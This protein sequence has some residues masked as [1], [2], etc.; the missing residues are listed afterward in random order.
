MGEIRKPFWKRLLWP[1]VLALLA[2]CAL[3][4]DMSV[5]HYFH[6][7]PWRGDLSKAVALC[8]AFGY[9]GTVLFILL[10]AACLDPR[11][12]RVLPRLALASYGGGLSA[13]LVK[14]FVGRHR[15]LDEKHLAETVLETFTSW[16]GHQHVHLTQS[17]PSAHT[18]T[19]AGLACGLAYF[20]PRG[21]W[22]FIVLAALAGLQ[23]MHSRE[24]YLSDVLAGAAVGTLAGILATS[25][26]ATNRWMDALENAPT[27][28][29]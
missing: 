11:G 20:Y 7:N 1:A 23:R 26:L 13:N 27:P 3:G 12:W 28:K 24:H 17:F 25:P 9:A 10:A 8:E 5:S 6:G 29:A 15:P 19:A 14:L 2:L 18:A 21:K 4:L 16:A 22:L